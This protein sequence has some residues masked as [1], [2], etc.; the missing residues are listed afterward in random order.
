MWTVATATVVALV[1]APRPST[2][3][4]HNKSAPVAEAVR[5]NAYEKNPRSA[6][7]SMSVLRTSSSGSASNASPSRWQCFVLPWIP[8]M[9]IL[10][11]AAFLLLRRLRR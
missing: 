4:R 2:R 5:H 1:C 9:V 8:V 10:A 3:T 11:A 7:N 6:S